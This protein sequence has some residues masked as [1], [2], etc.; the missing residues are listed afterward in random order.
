MARRGGLAN[1]SSLGAGI[2]VVASFFYPVW[3]LTAKAATY[4]QDFPE[5]L[6]VYVYLA[7]VQG[8]LY[9]FEILNK[10]IGAQFPA[11]VP[12]HVVFPV[13]FGALALLCF[14]AVFL[15]PWKRRALQLALALFVLLGIAGSA[16]LQWRL[17]AFGHD[18]NPNSPVTVPD[19]TVPLVGPTKL[20]NWS[21]STSLDTGAYTLVVAA[22]LVALAYVL[23][24]RESRKRSSREVMP[25]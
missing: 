5:G 24:H 8:D 13:L 18:R 4:Q 16:S 20:Y 17:Y 15:N 23:V 22:V 25:A 9:E 11:R 14:A 10:W 12:E 1:L 2:L 6:K 7:K 21:I 19:F 3:C